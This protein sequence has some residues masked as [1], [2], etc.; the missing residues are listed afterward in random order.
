MA[1]QRVKHIFYFSVWGAQS[2]GPWWLFK[3]NWEKGNLFSHS[4]TIF[5][6]CVLRTGSG[7][8]TFCVSMNK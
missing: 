1:Q 4:W 8:C 7:K 3:L 2:H 6:S 5:L